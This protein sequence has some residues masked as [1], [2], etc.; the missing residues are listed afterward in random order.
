[1]YKWAYTHMHT[2]GLVHIGHITVI[3]AAVALGPG[4]APRAPPNAPAIP[5]SVA[6]HVHMRRVASMSQA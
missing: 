1:M 2:C 3:S 6:P 4:N 5:A